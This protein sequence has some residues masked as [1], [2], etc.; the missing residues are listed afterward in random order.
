[1]CKFDRRNWVKSIAIALNVSI[2]VGKDKPARL[3][4]LLKAVFFRVS[5]V[6]FFP[7][8]RGMC[9]PSVVDLDKRVIDHRLGGAF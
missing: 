6:G 7:A 3:L 4:F 9:W 5:E 1:M 8:R 2:F